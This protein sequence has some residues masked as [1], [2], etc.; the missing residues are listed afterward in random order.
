MEKTAINNNLN[1]EKDNVIVTKMRTLGSLISTR[2]TKKSGTQGTIDAEYRQ[3]FQE[4]VDKIERAYQREKK[5]QESVGETLSRITPTSSLI[6]VAM[7]LTETG[8]IKETPILKQALVIITNLR[9]SISAKF[10]TINS[11][12]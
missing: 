1:A 12:G 8:K 2:I 7:N 6:Y 10:Q 11:R 5:R 4:Q 3:K 9:R